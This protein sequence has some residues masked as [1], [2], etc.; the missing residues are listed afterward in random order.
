MSSQSQ[1][2]L[3][4]IVV[5]GG[6]VGASLAWHLSRQKVSLTIVASEIGGAATPNSFAWLNAS[7][8][9][10]K[11]YY[12][13]RRRSM[14]RWRQL[15]DEVPG[16]QDLIRWCGSLQWD[17]SPDQLAKYEK[18]HSAW[19]Y[20]IRRAERQEMAEREPWLAEKVLPDW[21]LR[22]GEEGTVE[23][24]EAAALMVAQAQANG[25]R[26]VSATVTSLVKDGTRVTGV[27]TAAGDHISADHVVLAA[28]VGSAQLCASVGVAL[29]V[30]GK[31]GLL[32]HSKPVA[33]RIANGLLLASGVHVRQQVDGRLL[34][35]SGFAGGDP[36]QDPQ[37]TAEELFAKVKDLFNLESGD[38]DTPELDF[39]TIGHRPTP[40]D[41]LPI[42]GASGLEGLDL[43][44]MHSGVTLAAIVGEV[45]TEKIVNGK[46]DPDLDAF[47]LGRFDSANG[48]QLE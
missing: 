1:D 36:G 43:A 48:A 16:L 22:I 25:A 7:W 41:G 44:V 28:G 30:T 42:L 14:A 17:L 35:G 5:G 3:S 32:V 29:P 26:V 31:A 18:E 27:I 23:A 33:K 11:F 13:F 10:P 6:I 4:V 39:F 21:G 15:A 47:A 12:D 8:H 46:M 45:L 19:G 2:K 38:V 34:A 20:D 9:N 24:A 37:A 40:K